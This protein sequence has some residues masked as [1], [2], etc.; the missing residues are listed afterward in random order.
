MI[1]RARLAR[2]FVPMHEIT[3][4]DM[5]QD[6]ANDVPPY[7]LD[8]I[9]V[10][11]PQDRP[12]LAVIDDPRAL[13][14]A[15]NPLHAVSRMRVEDRRPLLKPPHTHC[16]GRYRQ[17]FVIDLII[18]PRI[19]PHARAGREY[20]LD[21]SRR[22]IDARRRERRADMLHLNISTLGKRGRRLDGFDL[23]RHASLSLGFGSRVAERERVG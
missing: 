6:S 11:K 16:I 13:D 8:L 4:R 5:T 23:G 3:D 17:F 12:R 22:D 10:R 18:D 9:A 2:D 7:R 20:D 1:D 21:G 15:E 19:A 14:D